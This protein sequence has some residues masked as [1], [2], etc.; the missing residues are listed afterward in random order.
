MTAIFQMC[1]GNPGNKRF[2]HLTVAGFFVAVEIWQYG[3]ELLH[4]NQY[5]IRGKNKQD[6]CRKKV[7]YL[8]KFT[9]EI[10]LFVL[11]NKASLC[12]QKGLEKIFYQSFL[13]RK[14]KTQAIMIKNKKSS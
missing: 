3:D 6:F 5:D 12:F 14:R 2:A 8:I 1:Q 13:K 9:E 7:N 10:N 11:Y 4:K